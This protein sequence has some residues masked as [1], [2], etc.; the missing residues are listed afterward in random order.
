ME[1]SGAKR[2]AELP[3][4]EGN[5]ENDRADTL[6]DACQEGAAD[7]DVPAHLSKMTKPAEVPEAT[8]NSGCSVS[9]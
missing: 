7:G 1:E 4:H 8:Q 5:E 6:S 2:P 9:N 3:Q